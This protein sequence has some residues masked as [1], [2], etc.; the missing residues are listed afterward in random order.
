LAAKLLQGKPPELLEDA[1]IAA[2]A[3]TH[4]LTVATRNIEDFKQFGVATVNPFSD[5]R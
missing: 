5:T 2:I 1:M 4:R 3:A